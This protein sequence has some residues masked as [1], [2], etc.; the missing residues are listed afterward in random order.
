MAMDM[1]SEEIEQEHVNPIVSV[2]FNVHVDGFHRLLR[3]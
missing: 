2:D 3:N 1:E